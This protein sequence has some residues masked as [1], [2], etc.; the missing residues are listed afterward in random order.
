MVG[1]T[2]DL[3][4]IGLGDLLLA[5]YETRP[6]Y[7]PEA[8]TSLTL[9]ATLSAR[10]TTPPVAMLSG[11]LTPAQQFKFNYPIGGTVNSG[12]A[13][14]QCDVG[15]GRNNGP[16]GFV[17]S[18]P[19][20]IGSTGVSVA[21]AAGGTINTDNRHFAVVNGWDEIPLISGNAP[22]ATFKFDDSLAANVGPIYAA[23]GL[24][25][26]EPMLLSGQSVSTVLTTEPG[27]LLC[28][29]SGVPALASGTDL[30]IEAH[31]VIEQNFIADGNFA[32]VPL[33]FNGVNAADN[34]KSRLEC[35]FGGNAFAGAVNLYGALR[36]D[37]SGT[38]ATL[39]VFSDPTKGKVDNS[40][41][42]MCVDFVSGQIYIDGVAV[43]TPVS[44]N[45]GVASTFG[46]ATLFGVKR[47][48]AAVA[49]TD[50]FRGGISAVLYTRTTSAAQKLLIDDTLAGV[51]L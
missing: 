4:Q 17:T 45:R 1:A 38:P 35:S 29:T 25:S 15:D 24:S 13:T 50:L 30:A 7:V 42:V 20:A 21:W 47:G 23:Y 51:G 14:W 46:R 3:R 31:F 5:Y 39:A 43:C 10:G 44:L 40:P 9:A 6:L 22:R 2:G 19:Q 34:T 48:T 12:T 49:G 16:S 33:A 8:A 11:T 28:N 37:S 32:T 41:H 26:K 18:T 36:R 27:A